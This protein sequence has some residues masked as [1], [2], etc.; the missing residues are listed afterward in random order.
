MSAEPPWLRVARAE[1]GV[2]ACAA[3]ESNPRIGAYHA[4]TN[5]AGR[6][7]KVAWCSS[8][9]H[10]CLGR[11]GIPGTGSALA[12]S[13]LDWGRPLRRPRRGCIVVL[14]RDDPVGWTGHVGFYLRREG[15]RVH[16]LGGNQLDRVC[17]NDYPVEA[18]LGY[19][20][21]S[22]GDAASGR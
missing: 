19:R 20:W 14:Y 21:P 13:W 8:F 3:G 12:R 9:V 2:H 5:V 15:S 1:V 18:V 17:E 22:E 4:G 16:L 7:D 11:C 6:D 10:W